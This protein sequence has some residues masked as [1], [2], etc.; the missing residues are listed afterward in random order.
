[1]FRFAAALIATLVCIPLAQARV[2]TVQHSQLLRLP[3][4]QPDEGFPAIAV[5]IDG[6]SLIAILDRAAGRQ[7]LLYRRSSNGQW[8]YSR[9]LLQSTAPASQLRA[10]VAMKNG[11]ATFD[12][13]GVTTIWEKVGNDW[14]RANVDPDLWTLTGG[15]AISERRILVGSNGCDADGL[16]FEK[17]ADGVWR[18][19]SG[20]PESSDVCRAGERDV[21]LNYDYALVNDNPLHD[22]RVYRRNSGSFAWSPAG[23]FALQGE[24]ANR[25]GPLGL[26]RTVAVAPG[27]TFYR[28]TSGLWSHAGSVVPIDYGLGTG[29]AE[30]VVYR[31]G[32]LLTVEATDIGFA[33]PYAYV[34]DASGRFDHVAI[35]EAPGHVHD[36]DISGRS[37]VAATEDPDSG[38]PSVAV[39]D[40]PSPVVPPDAI[41]NDFNARDISGFQPSAG[42]SF[43]LGGNTYNYLYRQSNSTG[44][45]RAV[46]TASDFGYQAVRVELRPNFFNGSDAWAG[47]AFRFVDANNYYFVALHASGRAQLNRRLNGVTTTLDE[48]QI[49]IPSGTWQEVYIVADRQFLKAY[50]GDEVVLET[51]DER[52]SHGRVALLTHRTR[53]DFDNLHVSPTQERSLFFKGYTGSPDF[54]RPFSRIGGTW[55]EPP[56]GV[57]NHYLKQTNTEGTALA[58]AGVPV[59]DQRVVASIRLDSWG[60]T[61]PVPW[62]GLLA[63]YVDERNYYYLSVRGSDSLQIRKVVNGVVTVLAAKSFTIAPGQLGRYEL[64]V[65]GN[66]LHAFFNGERVAT[67]ID[68]DL[69]SG[70]YGIGTYRAAASFSSISV[71]Q[72]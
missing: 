13:D 5:A 26:Q 3:Q 50:V 42:S 38:W 41:A 67:A 12:I 71:T 9:V 11:L 54:G 45:A 4:E 10:S 68:S 35:L 40:L 52:L 33:S 36:L 66:E 6:D 22:V 39:Y 34:L 1:M 19:T 60:S 46:L 14:V 18:I 53:A 56:P 63:R 48:W 72:P 25:G 21:E 23:T 69:P 2:H 20:L 44:D 64:R 43:A 16:I 47:V 70:R 65:L 62:F 15:H 37:V 24:S 30:R 49:P 55:V 51:S 8:A 57:S 7:A 31:D 29:D 17:E 59:T 58:I 32:V 27:S 61:Q 28:R